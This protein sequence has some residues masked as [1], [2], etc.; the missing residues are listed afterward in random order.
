MSFLNSVLKV[1]VGDKSKQDVKAL[2]P[3][4]KEVNAFESELEAL[5][6]DELRAKT[7]EFKAKI[8]DARKDIEDK[9]QELKEEAD[10]SDNIDRNEE[11]YQ[12]IDK[13]K[14]ESYK[15]TEGVLDAIMA[16]A[17]A[18]VKETAKR[19]KDNTSITVT[20]NEFDRSISGDKDYITLDGEKATWANSWD[21]AGKE[22]TWDMVHYDV[23]LIGG[24]ALHQ[25]KIAEMQTG[26]GKT[27]VATLPVYLNALAEKGVHLVTVNDYL[28]KRDSAWMAPIFEFHGMSVDCIDYHQ[29]NSDARRKAYNADV[30][31]GTNNEFGFDYLRDNMAHNPDDL[32]QLP[33]HYAIVDE[34][35]SVLVDD[36][37]TPLIISG[38]IPK[39]DQHEFDAL[40]PK[41]DD[42]VSVQRKYLTGVLAEAK[43]LITE[44]D[45]KEGGFKLLRVYRGIPKNKALIKF[46]SEEGVKQ[47]LQKTE[48]FYMQDNNREMPKVDE[49]LYY[50][51]DEKNN[52]IEL[53]DKG[54]EYLSG[55]DNPDFFDA[56]NGY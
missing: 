4:I 28:A 16:E 33:H 42:I 27:L 26:E 34:V 9:I 8:A 24:A 3:I 1:F 38:P 19:F 31:Y 47:L 12:E 41:V 50:V 20:A 5:S 32:V 22:V 11:I 56:R 36:A 39:G 48:N 2:S 49:E 6:H 44:G 54:I 55:K 10:A 35:D 30:T 51:I 43:K 14:D 7:A 52:Q 18:V 23:Q 53:S 25:G 46:L 15:V 13:L 29:P 45:T 21:A 37:R 40:K 17:F